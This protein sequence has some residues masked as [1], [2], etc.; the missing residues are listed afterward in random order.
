MS[1]AHNPEVI[2]EQF[3]K[4]VLCLDAL[5]LSPRFTEPCPRLKKDDHN[6]WILYWLQH[7]V[8]DTVDRNDV[9]ES[10]IHPM[11]ADDVP[12]VD[13]FPLGYSELRKDEW[14]HYE[15]YLIIRKRELRDLLGETAKDLEAIEPGDS[16]HT[17]A[18]PL[19]GRLRV[20]DQLV[21]AYWRTILYNRRIHFDNFRES[22]NLEA[23]P[24]LAGGGLVIGYRIKSSP[25]NSPLEKQWRPIKFSFT[26]R[27]C[28]TLG[29]VLL[30][31]SLPLIVVLINV[32][33]LFDTLTQQTVNSIVFAGIACM[34]LYQ[35]C[36]T[37]RKTVESNAKF[38]NVL[39]D[40]FRQC[41]VASSSSTLKQR[42]ASTDKTLCWALLARTNK[43]LC[44][45]ISV[46]TATTAST[47]RTHQAHGA[48]AHAF[49]KQTVRMSINGFGTCT[50]AGSRDA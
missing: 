16:A 31:F 32:T 47:A 42:S 36:S 28:S 34:L 44:C 25:F 5:L 4:Y 11:P 37:S 49:P 10:V 6:Q 41:S 15:T 30:G 20:L 39:L 22:V 46:V 33:T 7:V 27:W 18:P 40:E 45:M 23:E 14:R 26:R 3:N 8:C 19:R 29:D 38:A 48:A 2:A 12:T 43:T 24:P 17:F 21:E 1:L 13:Y 35:A 9:D 50:V